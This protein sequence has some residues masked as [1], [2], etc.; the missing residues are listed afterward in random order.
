M[1]NNALQSYNSRRSDME[2]AELVN[3]AKD[4]NFADSIEITYGAKK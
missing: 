4:P 3:Q 2:D 1:L